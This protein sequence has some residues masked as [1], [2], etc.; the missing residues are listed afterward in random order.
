MMN[1]DMEH[2]AYDVGKNERE[3]EVCLKIKTKT[4]EEFQIAREILHL[5]LKLGITF[6]TGMQQVEDGI[7]HD[8]E[9]DWSLKGPIRVVF[10]E[11]VDQDP[12]NRYVREAMNEK[13]KN[14][15]K[16]Q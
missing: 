1:I 7:I 3:V 8:W 6:D 15:Q 9:F 12:E 4:S 2:Q 14:Q 10:N 11:F 16:E 13:E 5:F